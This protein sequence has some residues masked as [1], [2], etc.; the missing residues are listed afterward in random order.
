LIVALDGDRGCGTPVAKYRMH[1]PERKNVKRSMIVFLL[2]AFAPTGFAG[3]ESGGR[4]DPADPSAPGPALR[5]ESAF[6]EY[7]DARDPKRIPWKDANDE[8]GRLG[9]HKGHA[10]SGRRK[11]GTER[12]RESI[13]EEAPR[14]VEPGGGTAAPPA[15]G[16]HRGY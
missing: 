13:R 11:D 10:D 6:E 9:G 12:K 8:V 14:P 16:D 3:A 15:H 7:K 2:F 1:G 5:Y 4:P